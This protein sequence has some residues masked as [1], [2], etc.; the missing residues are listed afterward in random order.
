MHH[1]QEG[2]F[3]SQ[4]QQEVILFAGFGLLCFVLLVAKRALSEDAV[5]AAS[6]GHV[7][8]REGGH[9]PCSKDAAACIVEEWSWF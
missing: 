4:T 8:P 5:E 6:V 1:R 2:R 3:L 9:F 7:Q